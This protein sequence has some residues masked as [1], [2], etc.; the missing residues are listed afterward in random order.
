[1]PIG[2]VSSSLA[3]Y[4]IPATTEPA[5]VA[6]DIMMSDADAPVVA[7]TN[8]EVSAVPA[9]HC[10]ESDFYAAEPTNVDIVSSSEADE[11]PAPSQPDHTGSV[12]DESEG[13]S[14]S[15]KSSSGDSS[16]S[17]SGS[18]ESGSDEDSASE[19]E[20]EASDA[21]DMA[22]SVQ[23]ADDDQMQIDT[24][25]L[26]LPD[27]PPVHPVEDVDDDD[28]DEDSEDDEEDE[29]DED[30]AVEEDA[31]DYEP[32]DNND[33]EGVLSDAESSPESEAYEPPEPDTGAESPRSTYSPPPPAPLE[34]AADVEPLLDLSRIGEPLTETPRVSFLEARPVYQGSDAEILGV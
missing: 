26:P 14:S 12:L 22:E 25:D 13:R 6:K 3:N 24:P 16:S 19:E 29:D 11:L 5:A 32:T 21:E 18:D 28:D 17:E 1:M 10:S 7:S 33:Q 20:L 30:E 34:D 2:L 4:C 9:S 8:E 27:Q 15:D 31:D 23:T